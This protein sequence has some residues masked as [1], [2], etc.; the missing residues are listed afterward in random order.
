MEV[1]MKSLSVAAFSSAGGDF[2]DDGF[3][4]CI[5]RF[6]DIGFNARAHAKGYLSK[7]PDN[8]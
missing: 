4:I 1:A 5:P 2:R 3:G 6:C 7:W 8:A